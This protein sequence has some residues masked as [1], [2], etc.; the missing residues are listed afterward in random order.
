MVLDSL[1]LG[2][3][4]WITQFHLSLKSRPVVNEKSRRADDY[5]TT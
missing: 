5:W 3:E 4:N 1:H 2:A